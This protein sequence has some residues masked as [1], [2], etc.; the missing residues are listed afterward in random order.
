ME[1]FDIVEPD[2]DKLL[3]SA[4]SFGYTIETAIADLIDNSISA[5]ASEVRI[6][7]ALDGEE[8]YM[9]LEDNGKGMNNEDLLNAMKFG[10]ISPHQERSSNDLGRYGL[11][12]K[13]ASFSQCKRLTVRSKKANYGSVLACWDLDLVS[14]K[15]RW[16]LLRQVSESDKKIGEIQNSESG[17]IVFW[18]KLD[19]FLEGNFV[20]SSKEHLY[21]KIESIR[22]YIGLIF[23][24]FIQGGEVQFFL[25][26]EVIKPLSPFDISDSFPSLELQEE[27]ISIKGNLIR[28]QPYILPRE[29]RL[30][31]SE[32]EKFN[33]V[34]GAV[35]HQGIY[36]YR[37]NRIII[38]GSWLDLG[39]RK[40]ECQRLCRIS[41][42]ISNNLDD[43]WHI[44]L[45]K[46]S[47][48]VPD[49]IR[50]RIKEICVNSLNRSVKV[51]THRG[52]YHRMLKKDEELEYLWSVK[53]KS[54][55]R[56]YE[57]NKN[58]PLC[59][60]IINL[61]AEDG[62]LLDNYLKLLSQAIP[63]GLIVSDF[64]DETI[65][66]KDLDKTAS[67]EDSKVRLN[68]I[69]TL[70]ESGLTQDEAEKTLNGFT[71]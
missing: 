60:H 61:L 27:K 70:V 14:E 68:I 45:R 52:S 17:T 33:L 64:S 40:K 66:L 46:S 50:K 4:R 24:R 29:S 6:A 18:E 43:E 48:K 55:R 5:E 56:I 62:N 53:T 54:N 41:I 15:K 36:L 11:G 31:Q 10:S 30:S 71:I 44:D 2:P 8:V 69:K 34:Y 25:N 35:G 12:L 49:L 16:I 32:L 37:N 20:Q 1:E 58:H 19:R 26:G 63:I 65:V 57:V 7:F 23:H 67:L 47:A 9:R 42:D 38:H 13:T 51:Y 21:R 28:V 3:D 59:K 22:K 39:I